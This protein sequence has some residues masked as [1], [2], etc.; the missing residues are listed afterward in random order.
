ML[1]ELMELMFTAN[2]SNEKDVLGAQTYMAY[3]FI[4]IQGND[5]NHY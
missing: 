1:I 4:E 2:W 3:M 5:I